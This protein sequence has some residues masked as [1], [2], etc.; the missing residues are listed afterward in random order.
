MPDHTLDGPW[1]WLE[2]PFPFGTAT[3]KHYRSD[4]YKSKVIFNISF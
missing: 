1:G 3:L 4:E 2:V